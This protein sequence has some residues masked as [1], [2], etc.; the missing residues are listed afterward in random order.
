[1]GVFFYD[2]SAP[3]FLTSNVSSVSVHSRALL[4]SH[5]VYPSLYVHFSFL[6]SNAI[7]FVCVCD[8]VTSCVCVC[9]C[10]CV[11]GEVDRVRKK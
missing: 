9:V 6:G 5:A 4:S 2:P 11:E 8:V 3:F 7:V 1:M 10:V